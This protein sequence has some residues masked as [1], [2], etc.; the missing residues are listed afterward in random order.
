VSPWPENVYRRVTDASFKAAGTSLKKI[1]NSLS[2]NCHNLSSFVQK[3][4]LTQKARSKNEGGKGEGGGNRRNA[5]FVPLNR[6]K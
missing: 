2:S 6:L 1:N 4:I 5:R 3:K